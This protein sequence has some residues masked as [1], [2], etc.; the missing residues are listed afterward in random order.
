MPLLYIMCLSVIL[1]DGLQSKAL[2]KQ[3]TKNQQV[4]NFSTVWK[5]R[6][7]TTQKI[8]LLKI[9]SLC[10][11]KIAI[12]KPLI[13]YFLLSL[14]VLKVQNKYNFAGNTYI[15]CAVWHYQP[16]MIETAL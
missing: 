2:K 16:E 12:V 11:V 14:L 8:W 7:Q 10:E 4:P 13:L 5:V 6:E 15:F 3:W 9:Y 1:A